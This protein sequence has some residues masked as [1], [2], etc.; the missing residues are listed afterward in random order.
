MAANN[1]K[2]FWRA[3]GLPDEIDEHLEALP[4]VSPAVEFF[5]R[6]F[7]SELI[8]DRTIPLK[9]KV[10]EKGFLSWS[11][12]KTDNYNWI[13]VPNYNIAT[14]EM[15]SKL[16]LEE[17]EDKSIV[18]RNGDNKRKSSFGFIS[19]SATNGK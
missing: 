16:R 19:F 6:N 1:C 8:I 7:L 18:V 15:A 10:K 14:I 17:I 3:E 4:D 9:V 12:S 13:L 2:N 11:A 5:V